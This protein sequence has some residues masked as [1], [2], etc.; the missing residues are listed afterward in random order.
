[1]LACARI[2]ATH[3]VVFGGFSA[4]ALRD[5]IND[6]GAKLVHHRRRRLAARQGR[7][8]SRTTSTRRSR[9][10]PTRRRR[11][12][13]SSR[14][15]QRRRDAGRA[16]RL[17]AR[18]SWRGASADCRAGGARRPSTRCSSSTRRARPA[19]RRASCT[20]P[21]G[22]LLGAHLTT[23]AASSTCATTTST[24]APPTSAGS[25]AT[26]TSST[27]RSSNGATTRDVR[28]RARLSRS[29]DRFWAI[30]ERRKVH[31]LLH[32][33]DGDPRLHAL[34][35]RARRRSTISRR[36]A[37]S[38]RVGEP[39]NP[40]A[41]MWYQRVIGGERCPIVDTWWQT[42][43]GGDHDLAAA[44]RDADQARHVHAPVLRRR[45]R[46]R[47]ARRHAVRAERGRLPGHQE[48]VAVDAAR[49]STATPSAT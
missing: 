32:G 24:G 41:W 33:A 16:R 40:E 28:R 7:R 45:R 17:V 38:A 27:A 31:D 2:G 6:C 11:A 46:G 21:R 8:R 49:R 20:R 29:K 42:E 37:C 4:E 14:T 26:A 43:T 22:Y 15:R 18:A 30:I 12:S 44:R 48:A 34:G 39:I 35:R 13:S 5:R 36:C 23:Q 47:Q 25:P 1:M 3:T 10:T 19:S 9:E